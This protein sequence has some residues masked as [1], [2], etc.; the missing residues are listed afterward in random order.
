MLAAVFVHT[1]AREVLCLLRKK[2]DLA[3]KTSLPLLGAPQAPR[4]PLMREL[5]GVSEA[6][7]EH[8]FPNTDPLP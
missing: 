8:I 7:G 2:Y 4:L 6:E 1:S 3:G 5:S